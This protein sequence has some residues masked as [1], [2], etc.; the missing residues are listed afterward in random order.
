MW[1]VTWMLTS[2]VTISNVLIATRK[3]MLH[4]WLCLL[5]LSISGNKRWLTW[6][7]AIAVEPI[8]V[9]IFLRSIYSSILRKISR[10]RNQSTTRITTVK[11]LVWKAISTLLLVM[12]QRLF[13]WLTSGI[14][15]TWLHQVISFLSTVSSLMSQTQFLTK[16]AIKS[17]LVLPGLSPLLSVNGCKN[18]IPVSRGPRRQQVKTAQPVLVRPNFVFMTTRL[19]SLMFSPTFLSGMNPLLWTIQNC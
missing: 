11:L 5:L 6:M 7:P 9:K 4:L 12:G 14:T 18:V 13:S 10:H 1:S 3:L 2:W 17:L 15:V 8:L 16:A 19:L